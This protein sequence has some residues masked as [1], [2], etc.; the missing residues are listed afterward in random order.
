MDKALTQIRLAAL[1]DAMRQAIKDPNVPVF[2]LDSITAMWEQ[3]NMS[4]KRF[5]DDIAR[6]ATGNTKA[7]AHEKG[8]CIQCK[9]PPVFYSEAGRRE[10]RISGMCEPCFDALTKEEDEGVE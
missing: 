2:V 6:I 3:T 9:Q 8:I 7:E 10:Y 5:Q 4:L 1:E